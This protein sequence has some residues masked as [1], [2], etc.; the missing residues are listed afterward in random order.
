MNAGFCPGCRR[1]L[2]GGRFVACPACGHD[3]AAQG[4]G[5]STGHPGSPPHASAQQGFDPHSTQPQGPR[6]LGGWLIL[7]GIGLVAGVLRLLVTI[8]Q[9]FGPLFRDGSLEAILTPGSG[10]YAPLV[11]SFVVLEIATNLCLVAAYAWLIVL[12]FRRARTF[13][14]LFVWMMVI[15]PCVIV[16]DLWIGSILLEQSMV[17]DKDTARDLVRG[18]VAAAIWIPYMRMSRRVR[19]TFVA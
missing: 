6:G 7:V 5:A 17:I 14:V 11:G 1:P 16:I 18:V 9:E 12:F 2:G 4:Q 13:P 19:N 15:H 8:V 10:A 3:L